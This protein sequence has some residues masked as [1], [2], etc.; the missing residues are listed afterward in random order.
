MV[1]LPLSELQAEL[2]DF[3]LDNGSYAMSCNRILLRNAILCNNLYFSELINSKISISV[4]TDFDN[5][6]CN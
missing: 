2:N 3:A 5:N 6:P 4:F 1:D